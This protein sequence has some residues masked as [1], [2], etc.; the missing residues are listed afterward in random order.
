MT[1]VK[2]GSQAWKINRRLARELTHEQ[3]TEKCKLFHLEGPTRG[4][5]RVRVRTLALM[6]VIHYMY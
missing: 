3:A 5:P 2:R 4:F 1:K 6:Y